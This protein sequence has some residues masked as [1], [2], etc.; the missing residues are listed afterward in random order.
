MTHSAA[1]LRALERGKV[2]RPLGEGEMEKRK[3]GKAKRDAKRDR[4]QTK[5][6]RG[7]MFS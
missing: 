3:R 7:L 2:V 6:L 4:E 1:E 5:R